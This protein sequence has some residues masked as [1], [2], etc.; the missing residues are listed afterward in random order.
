LTIVDLIQEME[1]ELFDRQLASPD[2]VFD[3]DFDQVFDKNGERVSHKK[4]ENSLKRKGPKRMI[5]EVSNKE[6]IKESIK[7]SNKESNKE[8]IKVSIKESNKVSNKQ[9][10]KNR[11]CQLQSLCRKLS[12]VWSGQDL[13]AV[14]QGLSKPSLVLM[15][16][17]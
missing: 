5:D 2:K 7:Q 1:D 17:R 6:S 8:S 16:L 3:W 15:Y 11:R 9:S 10:N 14:E 12:R 4:T 13:E